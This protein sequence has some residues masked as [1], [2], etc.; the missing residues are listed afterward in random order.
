MPT[1]VHFKLQSDKR[2]YL[3]LNTY[4]KCSL[5]RCRCT[6]FSLQNYCGLN[7]QFNDI[8]THSNESFHSDKIA[9]IS[10]F[11]FRAKT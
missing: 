1:S 8:V 2:F 10:G 4:F 6:R 7:S 5:K 9:I 11:A 3:K